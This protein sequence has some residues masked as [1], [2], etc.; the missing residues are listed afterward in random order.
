[1]CRT[2]VTWFLLPVFLLSV[3]TINTYFGQP[4]IRSGLFQE[5]LKKLFKSSP[6]WSCT[7]PLTCL[8]TLSW[9]SLSVPKCPGWFLGRTHLCCVVLTLGS[10]L[11]L[12]VKIAKNMYCTEIQSDYWD[13][14]DKTLVPEI[15]EGCVLK[16]TI[17]VWLLKVR[18]GH[19]TVRSNKHYWTVSVAFQK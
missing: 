10:S 15:N 19:L 4:H 11:G 1:M 16:N 2:T 14:H 6:W 18:V 17:L 8:K 12:K 9:R 7:Y 5:Q 3:R 13:F